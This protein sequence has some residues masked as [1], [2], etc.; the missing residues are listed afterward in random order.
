MAEPIPG[1]SCDGRESILLV[2]DESMMAEV[3]ARY[4][5]QAGYAVDL[6]TTGPEALELF[7]QRQPRL[8]LLDIMLPGGV[9]GF[10]ICRHIRATTATPVIMLTARAEEVDKVLGLGLG[11][12]DYV[13]KP[14]SPRELVAR[15]KAVLRRSAAAGQPSA[16]GDLV[17]GSLRINPATRAV[18][19]ALGPAE[20]TAREFDL[21]LHLARHPGQV[22]TR[23]QLLDTVW[24]YRFPGEESTV[25]V[26]MHRLREKVEDDAARPRFLKTVWGVGYKF[27]A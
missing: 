17:F 21:L 2:E 5:E 11:A 27:D 16:S 15:V 23:A 20:L 18:A 12:D 26:H 25:T 4:L 9:D 8:V 7:R 13:T 24:D 6:A 19:T 14:F 22:F 1:A 10:E 3:V